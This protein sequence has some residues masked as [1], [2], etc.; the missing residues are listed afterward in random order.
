MVAVKKFVQPTSS[1]E[2]FENELKLL[3]ELK[4]PNIVQLLGYCYE[5]RKLHMFHEGEY[6]FAEDT[7]TLLCLECLPNGSL[8]KYISGMMFICEKTFV[9]LL[10]IF[11]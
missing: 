9:S 8:E 5:T 3:M 7:Q 4:H 2:E 11:P 10:L 1:Q 6:I